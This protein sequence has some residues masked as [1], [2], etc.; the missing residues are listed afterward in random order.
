MFDWNHAPVALLWDNIMENFHLS[1]QGVGPGYTIPPG[2]T[3]YYHIQLGQPWVFGGLTVGD[4]GVDIQRDHSW[5][6]GSPDGRYRFTLNLND[7][8]YEALGVTFT[9]LNGS[10]AEIRFENKEATEITIPTLAIWGYP[11]TTFHT[12]QFWHSPDV[13]DE[14]ATQDSIRRYGQQTYNYQGLRSIY[15]DLAQA[16]ADHCVR[17]YR[18]GVRT[19]QVRLYGQQNGEDRTKQ[20]AC[21]DLAP[22]QL[23]TSVNILGDNGP[24]ILASKKYAARA[25]QPYP[26][27]RSVHH[28]WQNG[29]HFIDLTIDELPEQANEGYPWDQIRPT[30]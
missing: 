8:A 28:S 24:P 20:S 12:S 6:N 18:D 14:K 5:K 19:F 15:T 29:Q 22:G 17:L 13:K 3:R 23:L 26:V 9:K 21:L 30:P 11:L 1:A 10:G 16:Y 25:A 4:D 27:V 7:A 2:G